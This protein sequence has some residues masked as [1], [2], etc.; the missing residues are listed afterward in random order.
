MRQASE[1]EH[2]EALE[3]QSRRE[4]RQ[5]CATELDDRGHEHAKKQEKPQDEPRRERRK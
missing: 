3:A 2:R 4:D 1:K 5:P